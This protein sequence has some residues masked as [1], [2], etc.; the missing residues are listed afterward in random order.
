MYLRSSGKKIIPL[1]FVFHTFNVVL[2]EIELFFRFILSG[3]TLLKELFHPTTLESDTYLL[4]C[5]LDIDKIL[6]K[7][8]SLET[9]T[10][11]TNSKRPILLMIDF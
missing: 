8:E 10:C 9:K 6:I 4:V 11:K 2:H 3:S 1:N 7:T 5:S